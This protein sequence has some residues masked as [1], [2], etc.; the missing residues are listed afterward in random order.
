MVATCSFSAR[1]LPVTDLLDRRRSVLDDPQARN[2]EGREDD[3]ARVGELERRARADAVERSFR[4]RL[5]TAACWATIRTYRRVRRA[6]SLRSG[7]PL[8]EPD[9]AA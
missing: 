4:R 8:G 5:P 9:L 7:Q 3:A 6:E 1:P 2:A